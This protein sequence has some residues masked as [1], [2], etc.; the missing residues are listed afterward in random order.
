MKALE[1]IINNK[2]EEIKLKNVRRYA[3]KNDTNKSIKFLDSQI[4]HIIDVYIKKMDKNNN[5][6]LIAKKPLGNYSCA[7][8][9]SF[10]GDIKNSQSYLPWNKYPQRD[11]DKNYRIGNG[12]SHMLNM[13]N[14][15]LKQLNENSLE[16]NDEKEKISEDNEEKKIRNRINK[17]LS[18][19]NINSRSVVKIL[20]SCHL[21]KHKDNSLPKI[22]DSK[23][24]DILGQNNTEHN[25]E[26]LNIKD[27]NSGGQNG[28]E[29]IKDVNEQPKITKIYKKTKQAPSI[30]IKKERPFSQNLD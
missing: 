12:F 20:N 21:H 29:N 27:N 1:D 22:F 15:D 13:L 17:S 25:K 10:L 19:S 28:E 4:R 26:I 16:I 8:C 24:E 7:S 6:W 5:S 23:T 9:D 14:V 2:F 18:Q 30:Y 11:L 3:D